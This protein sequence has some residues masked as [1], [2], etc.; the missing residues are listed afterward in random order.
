MISI[1]VHSCAALGR[2]GTKFALCTLKEEAAID[3]GFFADASRF[4]SAVKRLKP[5]GK[6]TKFSVP[7]LLEQLCVPSHVSVTFMDT[8]LQVP[9]LR[10][11]GNSVPRHL[12]LRAL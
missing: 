8:C 6:Y 12:H 11:Q 2:K 5:E 7:S 3:V 10:D 4:L 9:P 1:F